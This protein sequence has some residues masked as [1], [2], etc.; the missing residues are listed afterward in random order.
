MVAPGPLLF[1]KRIALSN[2]IINFYNIL[3]QLSINERSWLSQGLTR[4]W[5]RPFPIGGES[6]GHGDSPKPA[7]KFDFQEY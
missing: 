5:K 1:Q 2:V 7:A 4:V 3:R 6:L